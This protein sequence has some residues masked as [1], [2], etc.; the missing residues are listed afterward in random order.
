MSFHSEVL[1]FTSYKCMHVEGTR[2]CVYV[3]ILHRTNSDY[4]I[5]T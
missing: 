1:L 3:Y 4:Y 2:E 5:R